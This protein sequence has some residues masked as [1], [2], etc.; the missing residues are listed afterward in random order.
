MPID[1]SGRVYA[2]GTSGFGVQDRLTRST[3]N[4]S[5]G[6]FTPQGA[7]T[8]AG[9]DAPEV[10]T[11]GY[12]IA[13]FVL[14]VILKYATEHEHANMQVELVGISVWNWISIGLMST[15]FIVS[16]KT[17]LNKYPIKGITQL[18]NVA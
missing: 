5:A 14:L 3:M 10:N 8:V 1:A 16:F 7:E 2:F 12:L 9:D 6:V 13:A 11:V 17:I 4:S 15:L 18:V